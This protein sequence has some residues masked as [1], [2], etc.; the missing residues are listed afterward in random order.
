M[1]KPRHLSISFT[2]NKALHLTSIMLN[3]ITA[4]EFVRYNTESSVTKRVKGI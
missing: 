4:G 1:P 3:S 2:P